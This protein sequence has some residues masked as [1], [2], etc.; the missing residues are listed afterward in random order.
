VS[1]DGCGSDVEPIWI[2]G[3]EFFEGGS[4]DDVDPGGNFE[5]AF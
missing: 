4:F 1:C 3:S 5:F 2:V